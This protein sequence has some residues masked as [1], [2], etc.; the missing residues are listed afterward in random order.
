MNNESSTDKTVD[1]TNNVLANVNENLR[2]VEK[3]VIVLARGI[4]Y[5]KNEK[6]KK[7]VPSVA[8]SI[9]WKEYYTRKQNEKDKVAAEKEEMKRKREEK[10][11]EREQQ[12]NTR[13]SKK[14]KLSTDTSNESQVMET[15]VEEE[16]EEASPDEWNKT[17]LVLNDY[18]IIM[19]DDEYFPGVVKQLETDRAFVT[20]MQLSGPDKWKRPLEPDALW[21][22]FEDI[23]EKI[24]PPKEVNKRGS[25]TCP[26]I[27][28]YQQFQP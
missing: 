9:A 5:H 13:N 27:L 21:Y 22:D 11:N 4:A 10:K 8:T 25:F 3:E 15:Q 14:R 24:N 18:V 19:Y 16:Q 23:L 28:K 1:D 17:D 7:K 12:R 20:V 6:K 26:E 2:S